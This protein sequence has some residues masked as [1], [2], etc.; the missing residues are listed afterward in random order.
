MP[1]RESARDGPRRPH[2]ASGHHTSSSCPS[3]CKLPSPAYRS[4]R[5]APRPVTPCVSARALI[6]QSR[7]AHHMHSI[8][9]PRNQPHPNAHPKKTNPP[10][11]VPLPPR[12]MLRALP[13]HLHLARRHRHPH[14]RHLAA[15]LQ[16]R[17]APQSRPPRPHRRHQDD[18]RHRLRLRHGAAL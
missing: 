17:P 18:Q 7:R 11:P 9:H 4:H 2:S 6:C 8:I 16:R 13:R 10:L 12:Q 1:V 5:L 14:R 3:P 15:R